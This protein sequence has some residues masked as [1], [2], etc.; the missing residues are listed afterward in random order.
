M[1]QKADY[2]GKGL[3]LKHWI[4]DEGINP[5]SFSQDQWKL[6][7]FK[8]GEGTYTV[9]GKIYHPVKND[10]IIVRPLDYHCLT[11]EPGIL[12]DRYVI[13]F[14]EN[15]MLSN[16]CQLLPLGIDVIHCGSQDQIGSMFRKLEQYMEHFDGEIRHAM[17][18]HITEEILCQALLG[19]KRAGS[20]SDYAENPL[21]TKAVQYIK[22]NITKPM[23]VEQ[24]LEYL[25][26]SKAYLD[27]LFRQYM[28]TTPKRYIISQKL[29]LARQELLAGARATDVCDRY[30]FPDYS[31]FYRQYVQYYRDKPSESRERETM[32][33]ETY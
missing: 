1:I 21:V 25:H 20:G 9:N 19:S 7:Y 14:N 27:R 4:S 29:I 10:L 2:L 22:E 30:G 3:S 24:L 16:I 17:L 26:I 8:Q 12:Y 6:I 28:N 18:V 23:Q 33:D 13:H 32:A 5:D 11:V 31:N 15:L